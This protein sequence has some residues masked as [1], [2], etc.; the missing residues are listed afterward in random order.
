MTVIVPTIV[1]SLIETQR[2]LLRLRCAG[3]VRYTILLTIYNTNAK[4]THLK[5]TCIKLP[6]TPFTSA[7]CAA[8]VSQMR[9]SRQ[10]SP[11]KPFL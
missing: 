6:S 10:A 4:T 3:T 11:G 9:R 2:Q 7:S 5:S 8:F 1:F